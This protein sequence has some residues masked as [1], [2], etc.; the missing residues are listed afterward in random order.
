LRLDTVNT[1]AESGGS[2]VSNYDL[3]DNLKAADQGDK[4]ALAK[5][6]SQLAG[7]QSVTFIGMVGNLLTKP[8]KA[9]SK[10]SWGSKRALRSAFANSFSSC[11]LNWDGTTRQPWSES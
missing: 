8:K 7:P 3:L 6:R 4:S 11:A 2:A 1:N 10:R 5:L 9:L